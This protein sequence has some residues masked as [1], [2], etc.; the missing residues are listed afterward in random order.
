MAPA[1]TPTESNPLRLLFGSPSLLGLIQS[2][3]QVTLLG[4]SAWA[5]VGGFASSLCS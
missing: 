4:L 2:Q 1:E 5:E 3:P